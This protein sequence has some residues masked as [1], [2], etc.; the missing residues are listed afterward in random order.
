MSMCVAKVRRLFNRAGFE[1][2]LQFSESAIHYINI[3]VERLHRH[4]GE[5]Q[6]SPVFSFRVLSRVLNNAELTG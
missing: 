6:N 1:T 4:F 5:R 2:A 3:Q